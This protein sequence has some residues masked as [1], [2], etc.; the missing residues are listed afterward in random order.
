MKIRTF[1][2]LALT[3]LI[4]L[5]ISC[6]QQDPP[7]EPPVDE[8]NNE[9]GCN[10]FSDKDKRTLKNNPDLEVDYVVTCRTAILGDVVIEPGTVIEFAADAGFVISDNSA[11]L[12]AIGTKEDSI[13]FTGV[14]KTPGSWEGIW[15]QSSN[16]KNRLKY[17]QV[18][19]AGGVPKVASD[20]AAIVVYAG[21]KLSLSNSLISHSK[22][23]GLFA[24]FSHTSIDLD[25]NSYKNN[26]IPVRM[27]AFMCDV[28]VSSDDY[29][30]NESDI[31][32]LSIQNSGLSEDRILDSIGVPYHFSPVGSQSVLGIE[33]DLE[34]NSG[35]IIEM[36]PAIQFKINDNASMACKGKVG[37][38]VIFRGEE[39]I[40][41]FWKG[42]YFLYTTN[43]LNVFENV[44][45]HD[46]G[47]D[48]FV[49]KGAIAMLASPKLTLTNIH[50]EDIDCCAIYSSPAGSNPNPNLTTNNITYTNCEGEICGE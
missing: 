29:T 17:V 41:G 48:P 35:V 24:P 32:E 39:D 23:Y 28:A 26:V 30:G 6:D 4:T 46:A 18:N 47:N 12:T 8:G 42:L 49:T 36:G 9:I 31:F 37:S 1:S 44:E 7:P 16:A 45:I 2:I 38:P 40:K 22:D 10:Y 21:A 20:A 19:Y 34:I 43:V 27:N 33:A 11:S 15:V 13:I 3:S 14:T 5:I 50:F 25:S